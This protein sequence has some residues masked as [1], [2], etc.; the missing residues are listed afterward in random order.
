[1]VWAR[2]WALDNVGWEGS[3]LV[4]YLDAATG[5]SLAIYK[6][7]TVVDPVFANCP[8]YAYGTIQPEDM[9]RM[10]VELEAQ[11]LVVMAL[12]GGM[13]WGARRLIRARRNQSGE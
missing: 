9:L 1:L 12:I 4:V 11:L 6:D 8:Y 5:E 2:L 3:S 13:V 10:V 7:V